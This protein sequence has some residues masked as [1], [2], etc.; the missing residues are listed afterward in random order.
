[1]GGTGWLLERGFQGCVSEG[2][3]AV[4][5]P[6]HSWCIPI[7]S[8]SASPAPSMAVPD[9]AQLSDAVKLKGAMGRRGICTHQCPHTCSLAALMAAAVSRSV[10]F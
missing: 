3:H 4:V 10:L 1:M 2:L 6:V 8:A 9:R 7:P 5:S